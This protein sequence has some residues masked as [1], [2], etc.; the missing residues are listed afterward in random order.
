MHNNYAGQGE[1][2]VSRNDGRTQ[3]NVESTVKEILHHLDPMSDEDRDRVYEAVLFHLN[4]LSALDKRIMGLNDQL[5]MA[6]K[7]RA[8]FTN[9]LDNIGVKNPKG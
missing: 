4:A 2:L 7:A 8:E 6:K 5:D 3:S 1:V 9:A